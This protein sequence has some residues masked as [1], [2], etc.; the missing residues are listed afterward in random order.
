MIPMQINSDVLKKIDFLVGSGD[1]L[2]SSDKTPCRRIFDEKVISF[3]DKVA[4]VLLSDSKNRIYSDII[5]WAFWIRKS[6]IL[7]EKKRY[8][9]KLES[10]LGRGIAFHIAPSNVPVNFAVSLVSSLLAGNI[11]IVRVSSKDF[12]QVKIICEALSSVLLQDEFREL[13]PYI[14]IV[15][16]E[17]DTEISSILSSACDLRIVW[18][19]NKT[20]SEF[21]AFPLKP[22]AVEMTFPDRHSFVIID[23]DAYLKEDPKKIANL[24]YIDT[25]FSDQNAC[26][27]PRAVIWCGKNIEQSRAVFWDSIQKL[28]DEKYSMEPILA[29]DKLNSFCDLVLSEES[30]DFVV[31]KEGADNRIVRVEVNSL[32]DALMSYKMGGGYFFEYVTE[33]LEE[34]VPLCSKECQTVSYLGVDPEKIKALVLNHGLYGVD[35][36]VPIGHTMDLEFYWDGYDMIDTMSRNVDVLRVSAKI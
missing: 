33:N 16:Y 34:I 7:S 28:V 2:L 20:V 11:S 22:R 3:L 29:V 19:G 8:E 23:A 25:F 18:G 9:G 31:K 17:R 35:R 30:S 1:Y 6:S 27:S 10:K 12:V 5:A 26:S 4:H 15:R 13:S 32:N 21:R 24:F 36:I 14:I